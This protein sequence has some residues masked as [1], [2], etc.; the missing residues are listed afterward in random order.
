VLN[1]ILIACFSLAL[2][3]VVLALVRQ[4]RLLRATR[5][6]LGRF[7]THKR[8]ETHEKTSRSRRRRRKRRA[9]WLR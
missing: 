6:L 7:I 1:A 3:A 5:S 4:T 9:P 8:K 2:A